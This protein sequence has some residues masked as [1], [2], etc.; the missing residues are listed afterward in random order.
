MVDDSKDSV[1]VAMVNLFTDVTKTGLASKDEM[2]SRLTALEVLHT[3]SL[4]VAVEADWAEEPLHAAYHTVREQ[5][6]FV[7]PGPWKPNRARSHEA[8]I[9]FEESWNGTMYWLEVRQEGEVTRYE[10]QWA[11]LRY[12]GTKG[13]GAQSE[14][15]D[16]VWRAGGIVAI[17][18]QRGT[19]RFVAT[20]P[21]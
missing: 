3:A 8:R 17:R 13:A 6:R 21:D 7:V 9:V 14:I 11:K 19:D 16:P 18:D 10:P 12:L 4:E 1:G 15:K 20:I 2:E 5:P